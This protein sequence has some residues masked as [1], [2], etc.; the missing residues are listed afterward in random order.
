MSDFV[1]YLL[2]YG[3]LG[4]LVLLLLLGLVVPK[5][6][7]DDVK[8]DRDMWRSAYETESQA[9][10]TTRDALAAANERAEAAV[11]TARTANAIL[12]SLQ[13]KGGTT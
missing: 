3:V 5:P 10:Q 11:E 12:A 2:N 4:V 9:H 8:A 1:N 7:V 13:H 6:N